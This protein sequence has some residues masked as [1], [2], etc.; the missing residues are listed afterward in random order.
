LAIWHSWS[1][2]TYPN[3]KLRQVSEYGPWSCSCKFKS[4]RIGSWVGS[5]GN[6]ISYAEH[7]RTKYD[8]FDAGI[9]ILLFVSQQ[10]VSRQNVSYRNVTKCLL[11]K[12]LFTILSPAKMPLFK[13]SL[14]NIVSYQKC[15]QSILASASILASILAS[16]SIL[17][18]F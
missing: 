16:A 1:H 10:N 14:Y 12:C 5:S 8:I 13:M 9:G 4:R 17:H 3:R 2:W 15:L 18:V 11:P 7:G 6:T